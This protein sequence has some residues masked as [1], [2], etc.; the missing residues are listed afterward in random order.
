[1]LSLEDVGV[2]Y[3]TTRALDGVSLE[4][5]V[6]EVVC[7]LGP[8]GAGKST[9]LRAVSRLV[10]HSGRITFDGEDLTGVSSDELSRRGLGH[11]PEGRKIFSALSVHENLQVGRAARSSRS[12]GFGPADVYDLFPTLARMRKRAGWAL[13][14][15]EQQMLA[16]G[17]AL[18]G[19][20]RL[21]LLDEPSLGL[22][23]VVVSELFRVLGE[24]RDRMPMLLVEQNTAMA[25]KVSTRAYVL[26]H[27]RIV[28]SGPVDELG[29]RAEL[30]R[31]YLGQ[32]DLDAAA[33]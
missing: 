13:S 23:P 25:M 22:A 11:V 2:S 8:N 19:N 16:I 6:G 14:G 7:L 30:I 29:G 10:P 1:M 28:L 9:T 12:G 20:P 32:H 27:G 5:A 21:L 15:G 3:G 33:S 17:R 31:N 26:T 4:V 24:I 18:V